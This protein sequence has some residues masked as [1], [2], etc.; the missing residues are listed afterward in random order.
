MNIT[1]K[2]HATLMLALQTLTRWE[3]KKIIMA[4]IY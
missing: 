3:W 2:Y 4:S 1:Y